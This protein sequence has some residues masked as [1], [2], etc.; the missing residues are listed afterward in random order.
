MAKRRPSGDGMVRKREDGRWEG[1]IVVGHKENGEPIF[2]YVLAKTQKELLAK[3][4]RDMDIYQDAQLTEDSRMTLGEW[5][6]RW[7]E[8]YGAVT[9]RPNTLRS[10]EQYIRCYV[11]PYL[12]GKIV[13]RV[14]RLDIQ[15]LYRKLKKEGRVH[16][17]PE[18]G[19]ELSDSM[20]LRIHA[21]LHRCLKDAER[22]HSSDAAW[23]KASFDL[24]YSHKDEIE[25]ELGIPLTWVRADQ[26]KASWISYEL[27]DVSIADEGD[28][29][30]MAKFHA[31]WSDAVCNA[32]LPYLQNEDELEQRL[33]EIAG[34]LREWSV[35]RQDVKENLAKCNRALTRFTTDQ[36]SEIFPDLPGAPSGWGTKNHYFYEIV[37][38]TGDKIHIQLALS[39]RNATEDFLE[40]C[41]RVSSLP[42]VRPRKDGWKWWTIFRTES[43]SLSE[44]VDKKEIFEKLDLCMEMVQA[45]EEELK[46][47]LAKM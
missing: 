15:K 47:A 14:T 32:V 3:L 24:L 22:D 12:G 10:Y 28:W 27:K 17:H 43:V 44:S 39:S 11:K 34:V 18:Y 46:Q 45:F 35:T 29:P 26:Y 2:R 5:L 41:D 9:L 8:E 31:E 13:S 37:N 23:N 33:S 6:D 30:H 7:M 38:R 42:F 21:M 19:H 20:V 1:R 36:M 16:D 25:E 4:H 40:I